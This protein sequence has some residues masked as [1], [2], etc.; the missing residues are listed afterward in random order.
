MSKFMLRYV[1]Q[2]FIVLDTRL[3]S[4]SI[5]LHILRM[6]LAKQSRYLV[7]VFIEICL[8]RYTYSANRTNLAIFFILREAEP[9]SPG[10]QISEKFTMRWLGLPLIRR[11]K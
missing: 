6:N 11:N 1:S 9:T 3:P 8:H 4:L 2:F 5:H 7:Q 10:I